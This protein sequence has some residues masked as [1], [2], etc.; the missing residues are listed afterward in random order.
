MLLVHPSYGVGPNVEQDN[1][2]LKIKSV[3]MLLDLA[4]QYDV[5][6]DTI[7]PLG[8]FWRGRDGVMLDARYD[9]ARGYY[10]SIVTGE[11]PAPR[12]SLEFG[13]HL[14]SFVSPEGGTVT[15]AKNRVVFDHPLQPNTTYTFSATVKR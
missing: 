1:Q 13:D 3:G 12:F 6:V 4:T 8:D 2:A 9:P 14:A 7:G 10:G 5:R 11:Y 15:L